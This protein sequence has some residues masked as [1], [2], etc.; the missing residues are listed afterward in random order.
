MTA[1][2]ALLNNFESLSPTLRT[3]AKFVI[4]HPNEAVIMSMRS[5]AARAAVQPATFVRLAQ[6]AG[7][8][9]WNELKDAFA[10]DLGLHADRYGRRA[11]TLAGRGRDAGLLSELF[12]AQRYNLEA[13]EAG[14][15]ASLR[16]AASLLQKAN[17]VHVAGFR[18]SFPIA[19]ALLYGYRLF[20]QQVHL[21]DGQAGGLE[22]QTR[23]IAPKDAVVVI[24]FSPYSRESLVVA[25]QAKASGVK[26]IA[27]T[28][29]SASPLALIAD[30]AILFAINSPS[31]FPSTVAGIAVVEAL[32]EI[33]V[34]NDSETVAKE[35]DRAEEGLVSSGAY[36]QTPT[37]RSSK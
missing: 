23:N 36:L 3:A 15:A 35:I 19:Y 1:K 25:Q 27:L 13:T 5:L 7:F 31:F 14:S 17:A 20:R 4:D 9:G 11:K 30:S 26:V 34:A 22:M 37:K 8:A 28:D 2:E 12:A 24:S 33:L 21:I 29:S 6:Q 32:L 18:A 10:H 16:N